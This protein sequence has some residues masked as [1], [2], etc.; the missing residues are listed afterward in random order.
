MRARGGV[1]SSLHHAAP[2][3]YVRFI[4]PSSITISPVM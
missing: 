2:L 1:A 4:P 3:R